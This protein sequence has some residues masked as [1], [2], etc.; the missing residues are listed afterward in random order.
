LREF[1]QAQIVAEQ[2]IAGKVPDPTG[3][4]THY[5]STAMP[6]ASAWTFGASRTLTLGHHVFI[7]DVP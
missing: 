7:K 1:V 2:V 5:F 6:K 3:G 4:A